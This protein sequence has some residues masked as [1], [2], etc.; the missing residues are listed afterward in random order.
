[1]VQE[2]SLR[3][4]Q[5]AVTHFPEAYAEINVAECYREAPFIKTIHFL[6]EA[7]P[8]EQTCASGTV[9]VTQDL[10]GEAGA[11]VVLL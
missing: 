9:A 1:M 2:D 5:D 10:I 3:I 8:R 4:D 7:L 6:E 11:Q